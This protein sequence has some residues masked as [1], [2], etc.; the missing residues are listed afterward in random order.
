M[1]RK[2]TENCHRKALPRFRTAELAGKF[3]GISCGFSEAAF[4]GC[5]TAV[6]LRQNLPA[7]RVCRVNRL[8][9]GVASGLARGPKRGANPAGAASMGQ[10]RGAGGSSA[11]CALCKTGRG[12]GTA[13]GLAR[14]PRRGAGFA[15][16]AS[17]GQRRGAEGHPPGA[18]FAKQARARA[19]PAGLQEGRGAEPILPARHQWDSGAGREARLPGVR[20]AKQAERRRCQRA[21][22]RA[23]VRSRFCRRGINGTAARHICSPPADF[24]GQAAQR[25]IH[26]PRRTRNTCRPDPDTLSR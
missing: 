11:G 3:P 21:C 16:A 5:P 10:R 8:N 1:R 23:E 13:S 9:A 7:A 18:R 14:E 24:S 25:F 4:W 6:F 26:R 2:M 17:M 22:K 12:A 19:P 20:F 15:G